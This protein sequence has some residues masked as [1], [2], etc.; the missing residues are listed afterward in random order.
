MGKSLGMTRWVIPEGYVP[1]WSH[2]STPEL[3]SHEA[4]CVLNA[5]DADAHLSVWIYFED[6]EPAG[7]YRFVVGARRTKHIRLSEL[8]DPE[9]LPAGTNYSTLVESDVPVVVQYTRLDSR[10]AE[11]SLMTTLAYPCG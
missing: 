3:K 7:P 1:T 6:R 10:Q 9:P 5:S 11:N 4:A 8:R 2:G